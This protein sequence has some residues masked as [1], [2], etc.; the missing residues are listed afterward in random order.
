MWGVRSPLSIVLKPLLARAVA[1]ARVARRGTRAV[2]RRRRV[3]ARRRVSRAAGAVVVVG[4]TVGV[5]VV[6]RPVAG[7]CQ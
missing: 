2:A 4:A 5:G 7:T 6:V 1:A 3:A